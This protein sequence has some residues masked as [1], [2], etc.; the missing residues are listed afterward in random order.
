MAYSPPLS[1]SAHPPL[2]PGAITGPFAVGQAFDDQL[3][4]R[5]LVTKSLGAW[6]LSRPNLLLAELLFAELF[7]VKAFFSIEF[8]SEAPESER[9]V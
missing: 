9:P 4:G 6:S 8:P 7:V 5:F 1:T 2:R 3:N